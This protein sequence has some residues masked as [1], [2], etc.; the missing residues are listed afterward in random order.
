MNY[1]TTAYD[2]GSITVEIDGVRVAT[3]QDPRRFAALSA[4]WTKGRGRGRKWFYL[5]TPAGH[6]LGACRADHYPQAVDA[7]LKSVS[8]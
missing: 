1:Q 5:N 4:T 8:P 6:N 3:M 7:A 2:N